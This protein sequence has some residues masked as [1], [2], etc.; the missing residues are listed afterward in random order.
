MTGRQEPREEA[1]PTSLLSWVMLSSQVPHPPCPSPA[2]HAARAGEGT[3]GVTAPARVGGAGSAPC[4]GAV[5]PGPPPGGTA[6]I[7]PLCTNFKQDSFPVGEE[8]VYILALCKT[9]MW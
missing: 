1:A 5:G 8:R 2:P 9:C 4:S 6:S 3:E 7:G